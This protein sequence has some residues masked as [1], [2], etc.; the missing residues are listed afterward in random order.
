MFYVY[1]LYSKIRDRYYVGYTSE[2]EN[3]LA[4]HNTNHKGFTG[5]T[6]DWLLVY[7]EEYSEKTEATGNN[8]NV[9]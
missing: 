6:G 3:R 4:K 2:L 7:S 8:R 5:K 1:I 9:E